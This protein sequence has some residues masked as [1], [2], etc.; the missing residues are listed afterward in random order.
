M[1]KL[2]V[3]I[4][5]LYLMKIF[6]TRGF[7]VVCFLISILNGF[8]QSQPLNGILSLDSLAGFDEAAST[9]EATSR[10]F[11]GEEFKAFMQKQKREFVNKKYD[12]AIFDYEANFVANYRTSPAVVNALPCVNEDFEANSFSG[13]TLGFG[14]SNGAGMSACVNNPCSTPL[15]T[16]TLASIVSTPYFDANL[17]LNIPNSPLGGTKVAKLNTPTL[18]TPF[19]FPVVKITQAIPVTLTNSLYDFA[20]YAVALGGSSHGCC[21]QPYMYVKMRDCFGN[22]LSSCPVFS[23]T[24]PGGTCAGTGPTSWIL[25]GGKYRSNGW[26]RY[27]VD[28]AQYIGCTIT[29]EVTVG[30]CQAGG[31]YG[32]AYYDSNC[33]AMNFAVNSNTVSAP[34]PAPVTATVSCGTTATLTAPS[35]LG[36]YSWVGPPGSGITS[37]N[38][39]ITT[40]VAGNYSITM[41][42]VGICNPIN[43]IITLASPLQLLSTFRLLPVFVR[44]GASLLQH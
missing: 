24:A 26:Q 39:V 43:R 4:L 8:S 35:G 19:Q 34:S 32:Y 2:V 17:N 23:I 29:I 20:Y 42:P 14:T 31:H 27:S 22:L 3:Y 7:L 36:P 44:V 40:N 13:W 12:L 15:G 41:N 37:T 5:N 10:G 9:L 11:F 33:S 25:S 6:S 38:Q 30:H 28:L 18:F 16:G 21:D 1:P